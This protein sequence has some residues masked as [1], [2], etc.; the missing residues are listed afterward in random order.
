MLTQ[1]QSDALPPASHCQ[2]DQF[3]SAMPRSEPHGRWL[4]RSSSTHNVIRSRRWMGG[5]ES[6]VVVPIR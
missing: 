3:R 6:T 4:P 5:S 2:T 1:S